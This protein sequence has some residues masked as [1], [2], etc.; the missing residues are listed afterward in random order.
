MKKLLLVIAA[1]ALFAT[2]SS[3]AQKINFGI[4][5]DLALPITSGFSDTQGIGIGATARVYYPLTDPRVT[6]TGTAGYMTFSGKDQTVNAVAV[7]GTGWSM[8]PLLVGGRYYFVPA[9]A[10]MR[11]YGAFEMGLIFSSF[12]VTVPVFNPQTGQFTNE[13]TSFS[14]SDFSYQPAIGF[15]A[16]RWDIAVRFLGVSGAAC[17]AAR[18]GYIFN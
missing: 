8:I 6:L 18:F 2:T 17:L 10:S 15:E 7:G 3:F 4:G 11:F 9:S 12:S 13:K 5:A 14:G 1:V 16:S